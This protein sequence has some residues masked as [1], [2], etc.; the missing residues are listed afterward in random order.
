MIMQSATVL[1][2][3]YEADETAWLEAMSQLIGEGR[4]Q[5]LDY[6]HLSE[7]LADMARRD[8]R[9]VVS[10]LSVLIAH[11][12]K[13]DHQPRRRSRSWR[14]TIEV[15]RQELAGLLESGT[16]HNHAVESLHKAFHNAVRQVVMETG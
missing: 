8:K 9:E 3:L 11:R 16:L 14:T 15:Q 5:E 12:L 10:R 7:Y 1:P 2:Q 4:F 13:W 6:A